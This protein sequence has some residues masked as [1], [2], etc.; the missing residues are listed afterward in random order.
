MHSCGGRPPLPGMQD[1][2]TSSKTRQHG[3]RA[4]YVF[5]VGPGRGLGNGCRCEAC[6]E[7]NRTYQRARDRARRRPDENL[8]AAYIDATE[9]REH[10]RWLTRS[11]VGTRTVARQARVSRSVVS[12]LKSG[13]QQRCTPAI[14]D[15][16]LAVGLHRAADGCRI[17]A[18]ATWQLLEDIIEHGYTKTAI[19]RMLG[20]TAEY[21][22]L[23][24]RR[25]KINA[26]TARKVEELHQRLTC[27]TQNRRERNR[28]AQRR[29]RRR[30]NSPDVLEGS[31]RNETLANASPG[32]SATMR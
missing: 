16:V 24:I 25:N 4:A 11:G 13:E 15:R 12:A 1:R 30:R 6:T 8:E 19:A 28:D 14:A 18:G 32:R 26:E 21:P 29:S 31:D 20:S 27:E 23:Q 9:V 17:D 7:A 2:T 5:G 10:L 22:A 3:T